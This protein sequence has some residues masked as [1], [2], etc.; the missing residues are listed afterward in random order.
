MKP[1]LLPS[2]LL[3]IAFFGWAGYAMAQDAAE[4]TPPAIAQEKL[5]QW[6]EVQKTIS[7]EEASWKEEQQS[8]QDL[9]AL[10]EKE[11]AQLD[12]VIEAAGS[13]LEDA[14]KQRAD[15]LKEEQELRVQRRLMQEKV[16]LLE[17]KL[18]KLIP[19]FP[20]PLMDKVSDAVARLE[21]ADD[22]LPLQNRYR[23]ILAILTEAGS[24]NNT[25]T[26]AT[27][28]REIGEETLEFQV[29]YLGLGQAFYTDRTGRHAGFGYPEATGWT[30]V[31]KPELSGRIQRAIAVYQKQAPP[32]L[33]RLPFEL[34]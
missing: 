15:L 16:T 26:V 8:V 28:M 18:V 4:L 20:P 14:E 1:H 5:R 27:E 2:L 10:R 31:E 9:I 30:W 6:I 3:P 33:V 11:I 17:A 19:S 23:D 29:F 24:F 34:K 12:E 21:K 22:T 13:R 25:I 32:E 7:E